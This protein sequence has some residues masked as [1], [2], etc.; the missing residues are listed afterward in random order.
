[1]ISDCAGAIE[2]ASQTAI[3]VQELALRNAE[4]IKVLVN[5]VDQLTCNNV[6]NKTKLDTVCEENSKV[7][8]H[9]LKNES[10]SL[11]KIWCLEVLQQ[12]T[13]HVKKS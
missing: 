11:K 12:Q 7:K 5:K 6:R 2:A 10:Y 9:I 3:N 4:I 1:M 8:E 13:N